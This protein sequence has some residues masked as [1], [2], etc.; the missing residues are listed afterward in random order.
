MHHFDE[1]AGTVRSSVNIAA[2]GPRIVVFT[3]RRPRDC[4][5]SGRQRRKDRVEMSDNAFVAADHQA[6]A[7]LGAPNAAGRAAIDIAHACFGQFFSSADVVLVPGIA[8]VDE[9]VVARQQAAEAR[10]R[11]L[12]DAPGGQH[13]PDRAWAV[14]ER[15]DHRRQRGGVD[16]AS[17]GQSFSCGDIGVEHHAF[18]P[19]FHQ[20]PG[21][22]ATHAAKSDH[23][24]LH[25]K[26]PNAAPLPSHAPVRRGPHRPS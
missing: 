3:P 11:F 16:G 12:R 13:Q 8:A 4:A 6:I 10:D 15:L 17:L 9:D 19:R 5:R 18:M 20:P 1:M 22:I 14:A 25:S 2:L 23:A 24:D 21:D 7:A 26:A